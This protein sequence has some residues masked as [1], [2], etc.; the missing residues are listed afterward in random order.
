MSSLV[1]SYFHQ[2]LACEHA[3]M[4]S[5]WSGGWCR[6]VY[7]ARVGHLMPSRFTRYGGT[8]LALRRENICNQHINTSPSDAYL[9]RKPRLIGCQ[10]SSLVVSFLT[11]V[12]GG[13]IP[14]VCRGWT[15]VRMLVIHTICSPD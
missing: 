8:S 7:R 3:R 10:L 2:A 13:L 9:S 14:V 5:P 4:G 1:P 11:Y 6:Q 15:L 12:H